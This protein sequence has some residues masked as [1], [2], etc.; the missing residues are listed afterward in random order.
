MTR[1]QFQRIALVTIVVLLATLASNRLM[2]YT[3]GHNDARHHRIV[4]VRVDHMDDVDVD[5]DFD[6]EWE[7]DR[8]R[9]DLDRLHADANRMRAEAQRIQREVQI[10]QRQMSQEAQQ[11]SRMIRVE[12]N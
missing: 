7:N 2:A 1:E 11:L 6:M 3:F 4:D 9:F 8:C 5:F 12:V 10:E